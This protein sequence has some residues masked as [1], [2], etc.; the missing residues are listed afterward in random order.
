MSDTKGNIRARKLGNTGITEDILTKIAN[1]KGGHIVAIV[2]LRA[3]TIHEQVDGDDRTVDFL[4]DTIEAVVD[5]KLDGALVDHVRDIQRALHRNRMLAENG[6]QLPI[7]GDD[8]D[9]PTV[10]GVLAAR[11]ALIE[12]D[13]EGPKLWDGES[14]PPD[15]DTEEPTPDDPAYEPHQFVDGPDALC[16]YHGCGQPAGKTIHQEAPVPA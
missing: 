2:E 6:P 3:D 11:D 12:T 8:A 16:A 14:M 4:I 7:D 9:E 15:D 5:G 1:A 10:E 13:E